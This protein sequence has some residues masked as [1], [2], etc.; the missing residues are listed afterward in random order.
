[1]KPFVYSR[2]FSGPNAEQ[3]IMHDPQPIPRADV[4]WYFQLD[5]APTRVKTELLTADQERVLFLQFNYVRWRAHR[6]ETPK[7]WEHWTA[8]AADRKAMLVEYNPALVISMISRNIRGN[9]EHFADILADCNQRLMRAVELFD[10]DRGFKFSTYACRGII[11]QAVRLAARAQRRMMVELPENYS[12]ATDPLAERRAEDAADARQDRIENVRAAIER[13]FLIEEPLTL[14]AV[15][16]AC[17][18]SKERARQIQ[19]IALDKIKNV[20]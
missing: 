11:N 19:V 12:P 4:S 15:G 7:E 1:M 5:E 14:E 9:N 6:A 20:L 16:A 13:R 10:V 2:S 3:R 18:F 17:G 8:I